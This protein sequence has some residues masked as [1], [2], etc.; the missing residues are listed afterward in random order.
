MKNKR[1]ITLHERI[2]PSNS[3]SNIENPKKAT[4]QLH[5]DENESLRNNL[6]TQEKLNAVLQSSLKECKEEKK[7]LENDLI[8][9]KEVLS[10]RMKS[11]STKRTDEIEY[12]RSDNNRLHKE[13]ESLMILVK[14][15]ER[16]SGYRELM[17]KRTLE[18]LNQMKNQLL[19][20]NSKDDR[21]AEESNGLIKTLREN[22]SE[23]ENQKRELVVAFKKQMQL[24]NVLK[25]QIEHL[26]SCTM[27]DIVDEDL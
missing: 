19:E 1:T 20:C 26:T 11:T 16:K 10:R 24:I 22:V 23:L 12:L 6:I 13:V 7:I 9:V 8:K 5:Q 25:N 18:D 14:D 27:H 3:T 2:G 17:M 21:R 15:N 4:K